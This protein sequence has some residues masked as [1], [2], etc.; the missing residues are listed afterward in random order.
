MKENDSAAP[1]PLESL[2][3]KVEKHYDSDVVVYFGP[4]TRNWDDYLIDDCQHKKRFR[5]VLLML[6]TLGGDAH[7]AYRI[8]RCLQKNYS[9]T[10]PDKRGKGQV[11]IFVNSQCASAG[12][13]VTL[14]ADRL[15]ISDHAELGPLDVQVR[16]PD[17]V[18]DWT[19]GLTP[20][21]ALNYLEEESFKFFSLQ[22]VRLRFARKLSFATRMA[23]DISAQLATGLLSQLYD[24]IDPLRLAEYDRMMRIAEEYG[25]RI[26]TSNVRE[27][28][29]D[30]LLREYPTHEFCIDATEARE[31]FHDVE[32][33]NADLEELALR[34][35]KRAE[36]SLLE[37]EPTVCYLTSTP[38]KED[39]EDGKEAEN[40]DENEQISFTGEDGATENTG[41]EGE[42]ATRRARGQIQ[43]SGP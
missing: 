10:H 21:Q 29:I 31:L 26:K 13:L 22:F 23:A 9:K 33:P 37:D 43:R 2:I 25:N 11:L 16:K 6:T 12:T 28:A 4:I 3:G 35:G 39:E 1:E 42:P 40:E 8:A 14:A 38:E 20:I 41:S 24:Q 19:S 36:K 34:L 32:T 27:Q 15:I 18:G 7:A 5:N 30:R 17:E